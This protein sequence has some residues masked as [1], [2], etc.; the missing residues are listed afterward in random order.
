DSTDAVIRHALEMVD[1]IFA[2]EIF[3]GHRAIPIV[4]VSDMP[5]QIDLPGNDGLARQVHAL[6]ACGNRHFASPAHARENV[7]LNH[8]C[9][10]FNWS[11]AVSSD[12]T[13]TFED[14]CG[15]RTA[16]RIEL[17]ETRGKN[18]TRNKDEHVFH[19]WLRASYTCTKSE[20]A[21]L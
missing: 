18:N 16:L 20:L 15:R 13:R 3:L 6:G 19:R 11:A 21:N 5:M 14:E 8:E 12:E 1:E 4:L 17:K 9:G 7:P 10:I 2:G